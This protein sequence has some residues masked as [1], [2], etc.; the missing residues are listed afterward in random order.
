M[1]DRLKDVSVLLTG[2]AGFIGSHLTRRLV[3]LGAK[4]NVIMLGEDD[5]RVRD[6][7][8]Q[9][10]VFKCDIRNIEALR[11]IVSQVKPQKAFHLAASVDLRN[12]FEGIND[13]IDINIKG[14]LN[15]AKCLAETRCDFLA[16]AG[17]CDEY[18]RHSHVFKEDMKPDP[19]SFYSCS[20]TASSLFCNV[21]ASHTP[22]AIATL[23]FFTV[24]GPAQDGK[25]F[26]P[27]L[28][29]SALRNKDM[30]MTGGEQTRDFIFVDDLVDACVSASVVQGISGEQIN[31]CTGKSYSIK[32]AAETVL[33]LMNRPI[34]LNIG[35]IPYREQEIWTVH[36]DCT[37][38]N[39]LLEWKA[40]TDLKTGLKMTV[41][42]Y[43]ANKERYIL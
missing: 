38:A 25:M 19:L 13:L 21:L 11:K 3:S 42:W 26:I 23:R 9:I 40:K 30:D 32:D 22:M 37:K 10:S 7:S 31:I 5:W 35:A 36:G 14:T 28:I 34:K 8:N 41:D 24:Y 12:D 43:I 16:I 17:S 4:V 20:K 1:K 39:N 29:I 27:Q 18:G 33:K 15:L 2:A 6:V